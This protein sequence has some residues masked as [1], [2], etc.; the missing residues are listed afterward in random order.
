MTSSAYLIIWI[1]MGIIG[2]AIG[3]SKG[4]A[5]LGFLAGIVFGPIGVI[6]M[7]FVKA[8]PKVETDEEKA[9]KAIAEEASVRAR[10]EQEERIRAEVRA[11]IDAEERTKRGE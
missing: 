6:L 2:F 9:K 1:I 7:L 10:I 3:D 5:I 8:E 11:K 4:K